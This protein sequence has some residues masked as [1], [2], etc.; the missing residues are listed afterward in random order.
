[1]ENIIYNEL[2]IRDFN[3]DI[4]I[5]P[6]TYTDEMGVRRKKQLEIDFVCNKG[7]RRYYVQSAY[8]IGSDEKRLQEQASLIKVNDSFKKIVVVG[9]DIAIHRNDQGIT[10]MSL[11]DFLTNEQ[12]LDL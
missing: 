2:R 11:M 6:T 4:G 1:M 12:S 5:V 8:H 3:V 10:T 9:D 7:S